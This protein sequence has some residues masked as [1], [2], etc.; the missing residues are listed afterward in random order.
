MNQFGQ[1]P[2]PAT[3]SAFPHGFVWYLIA[4]YDKLES[5]ILRLSL[6]YASAMSSGV[7]RTPE[8]LIQLGNLQVREVSLRTLG[9]ST[10]VDTA[11][12]KQLSSMNFEELSTSRIYSAGQINI[13]SLWKLRAAPFRMPLNVSTSPRTSIRN[14]GT[15]NW[16]KILEKLCYGR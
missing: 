12:K 13:P 4:P 10:G 1:P 6:W 9:P 11:V 2:K 15:P 5:T 16:T 7:L 14:H 8:S 3:S